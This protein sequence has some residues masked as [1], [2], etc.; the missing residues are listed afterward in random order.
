M[1]LL[2]RK[3]IKDE[4]PVFAASAAFW[5]AISVVPFLMVIITAVQLVP[6]LDKRSVESLLLTAAPSI[7]QI[8]ALIHS[9]M[10]NLYIAAPGALIS[11]TAVMALWSASTGVYAI[12]RG[13][14]RIYRT[15]EDTSYLLKRTRALLFTFLFLL[16]IVLTLVLLVFGRL[17]QSLLEQYLPLIAAV[18]AYIMSFRAPLVLVVLFFSFLLLYTVM[19]GTSRG[20]RSHWPGALFSTAGWVISS[21]LFSIY[22]TYFR[23]ISYMY[24]SLGAIVLLLFWLY[25][26]IC[27]LFFGAELNDYL[28]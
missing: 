14:M 26:I 12:E 9:V 8:E 2:I 17:I 3:F 5:M 25:M 15:A 19:P 4:M 21:G 18:T 11:I 6:G 20:I 13:I 22:F 7:P 16:L 1:I 23:N 28:A 27:L 10:D 24:G